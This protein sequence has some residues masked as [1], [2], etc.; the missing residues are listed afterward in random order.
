MIGRDRNGDFDEDNNAF[1]SVT[2]QNDKYGYTTVGALLPG[3]YG[4]DGYLPGTYYN[5]PYDFNIVAFWFLTYDNAT[6]NFTWTTFS[7]NDVHVTFKYFIN[8]GV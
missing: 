6:Q 1:F 5:Y 4:H 8:A 3:S 2:V 7:Q